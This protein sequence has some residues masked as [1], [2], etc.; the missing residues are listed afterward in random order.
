MTSIYNHFRSV[1]HPKGEITLKLN[2]R[3]F[4]KVAALSIGAMALV[5]AQPPD[6]DSSRYR[7][8]VISHALLNAALKKVEPQYPPMATRAR[9]QGDVKVKILVDRIG[10]VV[11]AHA[12]EGHPFLRAS[13][14]HAAAQWQ[15]KPNFGFAGKQK[16][17]YIESFIVFHFRLDSPKPAGQSDLP[18]DLPH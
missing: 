10:K 7:P 15:F 14:V 17:K 11:C 18:A 16:R 12:T 2:L 9:I 13:A 1:H 5:Q 6:C 3:V 8:L 4:L